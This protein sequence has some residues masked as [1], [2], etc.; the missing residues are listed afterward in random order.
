MIGSNSLVLNQAT[1]TAAMQHYF[2]TVLFAEGKSPKVKNVKQEN[3]HT[4]TFT[5]EV[6]TPK[7]EAK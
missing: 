2:D 7:E 4:P 3:G 6:E 1:M 5:V